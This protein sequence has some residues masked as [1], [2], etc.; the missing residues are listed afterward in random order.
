MV[1]PPTIG[2]IELTIGM[3]GKRSVTGRLA[4]MRTMPRKGLTRIIPAR[5]RPISPTKIKL[6]V[7]IK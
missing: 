2:K 5:M 3:V 7:S 1:T 4:A 6:S